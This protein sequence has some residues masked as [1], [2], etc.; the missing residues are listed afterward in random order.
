MRYAPHIAVAVVILVAAFLLWQ[1]Y[2]PKPDNTP[3]PPPTAGSVPTVIAPKVTRGDP[4][5]PKPDTHTT[6][7]LRVVIPDTV[8]GGVPREIFIYLTDEPDV[9]PLIKSDAPIQAEFSP[10]V[11]PWLVLK[12]RLVVGG[13]VSTDGYVSPFVGLSCVRLFRTVNIGAGIDRT[14]VGVFASWE[15]FRELNIGAVYYV[16][17]IRDTHARAGIFIGY[18]F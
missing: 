6:G 7:I 4:A 12:A 8:T 17:P 2:G 3:K 9:P 16:L 18:R 11:D 15:F 14:A 1:R 5:L 10:V 13:S